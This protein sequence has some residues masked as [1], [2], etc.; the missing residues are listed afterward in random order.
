MRRLS[1]TTTLAVAAAA[2]LLAVAIVLLRPS[3]PAPGHASG[4]RIAVTLTDFRIAPQRI[5]ARPGTLTF[6]LTNRGRLP[7]GFRLLRSGREVAKQTT[8]KPGQSATLTRRV[9]AGTY[10]ILCPLS[11]H[12]ELGMYGTVNVQ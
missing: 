5:L 8:L 11:N 9:R 1:R 6:V 12:A 4:G 2:A 3:P 10:R 7:H